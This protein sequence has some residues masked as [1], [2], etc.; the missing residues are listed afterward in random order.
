M[1]KKKDKFEKEYFK[2]RALAK[3]LCIALSF[4]EYSDE[5]EHSVENLNAFVKLNN[6]INNTMLLELEHD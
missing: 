5:Y 4:G 3:E 6:Y 1:A 2:L